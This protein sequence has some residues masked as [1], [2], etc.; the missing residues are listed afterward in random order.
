MRWYVLRSKPNREEALW[1]ETDARG[2]QTFYPRLI[3]KPVNPRAR[4]V[5]PY[6]PGYL[7][8]RA[9]LAA[10]GQSEFTWLPHSQGLVSFGGEPAE[11]P[12]TLVQAIRRKVDEINWG[13]GE[14][15]SGL[16]P[17][18]TVQ[19][20]GGPFDGYKAIFDA[21]VAGDER[22]RVLLSLLQV[23]QVKLELPVGQIQPI[24][25]R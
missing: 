18:D 14:Q 21:R 10:V 1:L 4:R 16:M 6:F 15:L 17:G 24:N 22:V 12:E 8:V 20:Q 13:G 19:I 2:H 5:R 11:V 7:F 23:R 25:R 9:R 3:A